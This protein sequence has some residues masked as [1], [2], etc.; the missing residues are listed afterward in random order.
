MKISQVKGQQMRKA[1]TNIIE[2]NR[3]LSECL[4]RQLSGTL[5][6]DFLNAD[7]TDARG[8]WFV[9]QDLARAVVELKRVL[10]EAAILPCSQI[11]DMEL[12]SKTQFLEVYPAKMEPELSILHERMTEIID[13]DL[14][15]ALIQLARVFSY[16][17]KI[18]FT[19]VPLRYGSEQMK[20]LVNSWK[21]P[22]LWLS[23]ML[24]SMISEAVDPKNGKLRVDTCAGKDCGRYFLPAYRSHCQ[25][26]HN[27]SCY[28][29]HY[30][31]AYRK[32]HRVVEEK[33]R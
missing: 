12:F 26:Y 28:K 1:I 2:G 3:E 24:H 29:K 14:P 27:P 20:L 32:K 10:A 6:L 11:L 17:P 9:Y 23:L 31:K 4:V 15:R 21:N 25:T 22:Q 19:I 7:P 18:H 5:W 8:M 16:S 13:Y 33:N 30:M